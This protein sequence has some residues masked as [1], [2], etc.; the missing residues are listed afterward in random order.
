M[1]GWEEDRQQQQV[2]R[3]SHR[4]HEEP[5]GFWCACFFRVE[6]DQGS[7]LDF[8]KGE[9]TEISHVLHSAPPW[10]G[11]CRSHAFVADMSPRQLRFGARTR[12]VTG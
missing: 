3:C 2:A 8:L 1:F 10:L 9:E 12:V 11:G 4:W 6:C 7:H 5:P